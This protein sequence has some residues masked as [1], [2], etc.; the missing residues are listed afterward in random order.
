MLLGRLVLIYKAI[1]NFPGSDSSYI[2]WIRQ[3]IIKCNI[4][5][6][7]YILLL[8]QKRVFTAF[9]PLPTLLFRGKQAG[10]PHRRNS[11]RLGPHCTCQCCFFPWQQHP[12]SGCWTRCSCR[13]WRRAGIGKLIQVALTEHFRPTRHLP[14]LIE[15]RC[16]RPASI[17]CPISFSIPI[18]S[19]IEC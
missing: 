19:R 4:L 7:Q 18:F 2:N 9:L 10:S 17:T 6:N 11:H 14:A 1:I 3:I 12:Q 5:K 16:A 13:S 15:L 8:E